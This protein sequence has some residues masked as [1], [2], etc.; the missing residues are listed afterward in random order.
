MF[1][2]CN[3]SPIKLV[4]LKG[5]W[6]LLPSSIGS[7]SLFFQRNI[8]ILFAKAIS[9]CVANVYHKNNLKSPGKI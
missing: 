4:L 6:C 9:H 1:V 5:F 2:E 8:D 7:I 3:V